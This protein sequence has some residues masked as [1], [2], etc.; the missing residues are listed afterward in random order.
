[1]PSITRELLVLKGVIVRYAIILFAVFASLLIL[2]PGQWHIAES[3]IAA[4]VFGTPSY[5]QALFASASEALIPEPVIVVAL[6]PVASFVAPIVIAFLVALL[7]TF[8]A[9]LML[10]YGFFAPALHPAE[11]RGLALFA[12]PAVGLFYAG[13]AFA[14]A[15]IIP[16]TFAILYSFASPLG[17]VPMFALDEFV[18]SV[19]LLTL[20]TGLAFLLPVAMAATA[21]IGLIPAAFWASHWRGAI[22]AAVVFSA[23][24]T[25]DGSGVTMVLLALPLLGLYTLGTIAAAFARP[26]VVY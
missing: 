26:R 15:V 22:L 21:R 19:F 3:T 2:A 12:L 8:P 24:I 7:A 5:A 13:A 16:E 17:A 10:L 4:P 14:Y 23:V 1:M 25:P 20:S 9:G 6:G 18:S 11:R